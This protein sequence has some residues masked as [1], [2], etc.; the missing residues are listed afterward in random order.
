MSSNFEFLREVKVEGF[1]AIKSI[2]LGPFSAENRW[3]F[4]TGEN[5]Y[6]KTLLLEAIALSL[7]GRDEATI[8]TLEEAIDNKE[9]E[10][11]YTSGYYKGQQQLSEVVFAEFPVI[12]D[13]DG[14]LQS[15]KLLLFYEEQFY[16]IENERK[17]FSNVLKSLKNQNSG[18]PR[19][20]LIEDD[21]DDESK[22]STIESSYV[23]Q[24]KNRLTRVLS[25]VRHCID[26]VINEC[27]L[28]VKDIESRIIA[29]KEVLGLIER[30]KEWLKEISFI[31]KQN[32]KVREVLNLLEKELMRVTE[33]LNR[34]F[35][36]WYERELDDVL[37]NIQVFYT[38]IN[39]S[40]ANYSVLY[41]GTGLLRRPIERVE[42]ISNELT[43]LFAWL[44]NQLVSIEAIVDK[45]HSGIELILNEKKVAKFEAKFFI[46]GG[47][48]EVSRVSHPAKNVI[49]YGSSRLVP[50][51][52]VKEAGVYNMVR[53]LF[54]T[55]SALRDIED[56]YMNW[57][58]RQSESSIVKA[59]YESVKNLFEEVIPELELVI[60]KDDSRSGG[61]R[62]DYKLQNENTDNEL[63]AFDRLS[64]G[65]RNIL[66]ILGDLVLNLYE[67]QPMVTDIK[68][69]G[70]I[71][72]IDELELHLHPNWQHKLPKLLSDAFPNV[73]FIASTH[74]PIPLLGAPEGAV[75]LKV[76]RDQ[77]RGIF[78]ER[79]EGLEKEI[80][81]LLPNTVLSSP[82]FGL[83][84]L[85][86]IKHKEENPVKVEDDYAEIERK[87]ALE[88][89]LN[90]RLAEFDFSEDLKKEQDEKGE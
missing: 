81:D 88:D 43:N 19:D 82:L 60:R 71:V 56:E 16:K 53:S 44:K 15:K 14:L 35:F 78:V 5:G 72:L 21:I 59:R 2:A 34:N 32:E 51:E 62:L 23:T 84:D 63:L 69:L 36:I 45:Y 57:Y 27:N 9:Q 54:K 46:D 12:V 28:D 11:P 86:S 20:S 77:E 47:Q 68:A 79:L 33:F 31:S 76:D 67:L 24:I 10:I 39:Q 66:A 61:F 48:L 89:A 42:L 6:G 50:R 55:G 30:K 3:I 85:R 41:K 74:S 40:Q 26:A 65:Y 58:V 29:C 25:D 75:F 8:S 49:A 1:Y 13:A 83:K 7:H 38:T 73:Q 4:L 64:A 70:G 22:A 52:V 37:K 80:E 87:A 18:K 90:K 17:A